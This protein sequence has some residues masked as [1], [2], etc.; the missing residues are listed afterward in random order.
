MNCLATPAQRTGEPEAPA[1]AGVSECFRRLK[2]NEVVWSGDFVADELLGFEGALLLDIHHDVAWFDVSVNE[3]L[4][5]DRSQTG[6]D[7]RRDFERQLYLNLAGA[8]DE[9]LERFALYKLH[10]VKV[11]LTGSAQMENRGDIRVANAR[12][13]AGFAQKTKSC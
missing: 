8:F 5:V 7:L 3:L 11:V 1:R 4:L 6:G 2:W 9:M 13:R 12:C 10:R